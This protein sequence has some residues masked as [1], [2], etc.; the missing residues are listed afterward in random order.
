MSIN[1]L[2]FTAHLDE[3]RKRLIACFITLIAAFV[4]CYA[5]SDPIVNFLF[6]PIRQA[7]PPESH[8]VFT[9]LTEGFMTYL[10]VAFWSALVLSMPVVFYQVWG[11]I[12]PGLY[13]HEKRTAKIFIFW[14]ASLFIAG[15][16][17]GYWVVMP[18]VLSITLGFASEGLT[19]MPR[20]Q[21]YLLFAL[22]TIFTFGLVFEIPF[23]MAFATRAGFL[24]AE[25]FR[26]NRKYSY[27]ALYIV[28]VALVPTDIFSQ[29]LLLLPLM[30]VYEIGVRLAGW[31]SRGK[32][33]K[34]T[35]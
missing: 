6:Y 19:A 4:G 26:K 21:N 10:K 16:V 23:F 32:K 20:L 8:I 24:P 28:A 2:P 27:I 29:V 12:S 33:G 11:F 14:A 31:L 9:A 30:G 17:F 13:K 5:L 18:T 22:K 3:L 1:H 34:E 25:Y 7:L 15:G 35:S